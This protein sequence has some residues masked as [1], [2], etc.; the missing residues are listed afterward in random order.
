VGYVIVPLEGNDSSSKIG[1][2]TWGHHEK[3]PGASTVGQIMM[4]QTQQK[5]SP[6]KET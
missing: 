1:I 4:N 5:S 2:L 6:K 3:I